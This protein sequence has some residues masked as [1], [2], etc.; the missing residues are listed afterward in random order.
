MFIQ[1]LAQLPESAENRSCTVRSARER[2]HGHEADYAYVWQFRQLP[3]EFLQ[4]LRSKPVF[5]VL[6]RYI[7][8]D[9]AFH[10]LQSKRSGLAVQFLRQRK[11]VQ[12]M[13]VG[14]LADHI[15]HFIGLQ[16]ADK[17]PDRPVPNGFPLRSNILPAVLTDVR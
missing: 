5:R 14:K 10:R 4:A 1:L 9:E 12:R 8:L 16:A 7:Q 17:M 11:P 3:G 2:C 13:D 6:T 15:L